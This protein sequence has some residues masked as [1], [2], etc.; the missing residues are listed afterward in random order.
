MYLDYYKDTNGFDGAVTIKDK[1][2]KIVEKNGETILSGLIN[3]YINGENV[4]VVGNIG[5]LRCYVK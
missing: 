4:E 1:S 5:R 2:V 3:F